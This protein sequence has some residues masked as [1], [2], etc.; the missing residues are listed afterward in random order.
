VL[1][2]H[3][4]RTN[5]PQSLGLEEEEEEEEGEAAFMGVLNTLAKN[6]YKSSE[7]RYREAVGIMLI[8]SKILCG[9]L[10]LRAGGIWSGR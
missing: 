8:Q 10:N 2:K 5:I 9:M 7:E 4:T 6:S 1:R 3:G